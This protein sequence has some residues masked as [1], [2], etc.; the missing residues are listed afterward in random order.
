MVSIKQFCIEVTNQG[1]LI[2]MITSG[3]PIVISMVVGLMIAIFQA[4]TQ[5][6]EQTL[7]FVPK[8]V[9][10]FGSLMVFGGWIGAILIR[11]TEMLFTA[12][13]Q[14]VN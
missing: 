7:T 6:Q 14:I 4:V 8:I 1:F 12:F 11:Y 5:I 2:V 13:P 10:V 3:P 9:C